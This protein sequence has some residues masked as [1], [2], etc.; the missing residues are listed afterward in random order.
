MSKNTILMQLNRKKLVYFPNE[1]NVFDKTAYKICKNSNLDKK[2]KLI[3][4]QYD[5]FKYLKLRKKKLNI[6]NKYLLYL[7][8]PYKKINNKIL[9]MLKKF[10]KRKKL[11]L[12][13]RLHPGYKSKYKNIFKANKSIKISNQTSVENDLFKA[14]YVIG[15]CSTALIYS[16]MLGIKAISIQLKPKGDLFEWKKLSIFNEFKLINLN[17]LQDLERV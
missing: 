6:N 1:I 11:S 7:C 10:S 8:S 3:L 5:F 2:S 17:S 13:I 14:E 9:D 12:L 15:H 4:N 16:K